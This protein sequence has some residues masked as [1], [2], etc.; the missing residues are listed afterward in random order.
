MF[1][2]CFHTMIALAVLAIA[3]L[4][5]SAS[6][7]AE[8]E[9]LKLLREDRPF[10]SIPPDLFEQLGWDLPDGGAQVKSLAD[11][12]PGSAFDP[13]KLET[14]PAAMLGYRAKWHE[15]RYEVYGLDWDIPGL[16]LTP[17]DP[18]PGLPTVAIIHGGSANWYEFFLDPLNG[19]RSGTI[20]GPE[21][22]RAP[23]HHPGQ[24]QARR[25]AGAGGIAGQGSGLRAGPQHICR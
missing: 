2:V 19:P 13:R 5:V 22:P 7:A 6:D 12:A 24:L 8:A 1:K 11:A 16:L 4:T 3:A 10:H 23:D 18:V 20:S 9:V 14:V 21:G 15:V 25:V 17:N